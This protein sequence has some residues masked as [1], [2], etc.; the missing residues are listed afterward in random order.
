MIDGGLIGNDPALYGFLLAKYLNK[1]GDNR[2]RLLSLGTG[3]APNT[4]NLKDMTKLKWLT[5]SGDTLTD[6]DTQMTDAY[7]QM[8]FDQEAARY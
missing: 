4:A 1:K 2:F 3:S 7:L 8:I 5:L 6:V